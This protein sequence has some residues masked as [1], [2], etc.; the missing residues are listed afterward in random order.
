LI[1]SLTGKAFIEGQAEA[2][3]EGE[4]KKLKKKAHHGNDVKES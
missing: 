1:P 3:S 2:S 4:A